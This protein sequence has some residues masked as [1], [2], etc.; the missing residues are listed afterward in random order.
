MT[1]PTTGLDLTA[2]EGSWTLDPA[3]TSVAFAT[4][5]IWIL[6][7]KGTF[8]ARSGTA[9]VA[10]DGSVQGTLVLDAASIDTHMKKRDEHLRAADFLDVKKYPTITF[11]VVAAKRLAADRLDIVG[12]L[13][14]RGQTR[15]LTV[16]ATVSIA[17]NSATLV[18]ETDIDRRDWD[19][20]LVKLGSGVL[21]H[22]VASARFT[23]D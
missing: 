22:V 23:R 10:A 13:T 11:S 19:V 1:W 21:N 15:P 20:P 3:A 17:G 2:Y 7:T 8:K 12:S 9:T 18:I 16:T 6:P 14:V 5:A 4:K